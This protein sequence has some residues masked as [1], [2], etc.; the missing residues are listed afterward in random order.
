MD[1]LAVS[2]AGTPRTHTWKTCSNPELSS[3][4]PEREYLVNHHCRKSSANEFKSPVT[5]SVNVRMRGVHGLSAMMM[6]DHDFIVGSVHKI[7]L[8]YEPPANAYPSF[9]GSEKPCQ[10]LKLCAK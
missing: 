5:I 10:R 9:L 2:V 8:Q 7:S 1:A 6:H 4:P 3:T